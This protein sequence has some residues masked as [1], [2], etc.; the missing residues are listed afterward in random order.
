MFGI[1]ILICLNDI[2]SN[3]RKKTG[4][5]DQSH[6]QSCKIIVFTLVILFIL[7]EYYISYSQPNP[8]WKGI[9]KK[10]HHPIKTRNPQPTNTPDI[11]ATQCLNLCVT[12]NCNTIQVPKILILCTFH[13]ISFFKCALY[14]GYHIK[15][16]C[17]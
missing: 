5:F 14:F 8:L 16:N 13:D 4:D 9:W 10:N 1:K 7:K 17:W 2:V 15:W 11:N 3:Y 6:I 12:C